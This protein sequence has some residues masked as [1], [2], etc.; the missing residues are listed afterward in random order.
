MLIR[1]KLAEMHNLKVEE[2]DIRAEAEKDAKASGLDVNQ[3]L[4]AYTSNQMREYIA[5]RIL[6]QKIYD[7]IKSKVTINTETKPIPRRRLRLST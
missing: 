1:Y 4:R 3:L 7:V 6:R 2:D 5:D